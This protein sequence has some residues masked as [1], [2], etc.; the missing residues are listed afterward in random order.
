MA[1]PRVLTQQEVVDLFAGDADHWWAPRELEPLIK[2]SRVTLNRRLAEAVAAGLVESRGKG[3]LRQYRHIPR[4]D[5]TATASIHLPSQLVAAR[6]TAGPQWSKH[7]VA[8]RQYVQQPR[9]AR[10]PVTYQEHLVGSYVPNRTFW[11]PESLRAKLT[12]VGRSSGERPAGTYARDI[13][14]QLLIDLAWASSRLEGNRYSR[15]ET[16]NLIEAGTSADGKTRQESVMILNHRKAIEFLVDVAAHDD[17]LYR[18]VGNL[19]SLLMDGLLRDERGLGTIRQR[20]VVIEDSVYTP[21]QTPA[22]IERMYRLLC[23][24]AQ[25]IADPL[26][27]AF[28]LFTQLPYLQPFEDGNKRTS[29]VACNLPLARANFAPLAFLDVEDA[30][31][32]S[33]LLALYEKADVA[34]AVDLFEWAYLRSAQSYATVRQAMRDPDP[35]R[36]RLREPLNVALQGVV[37]RGLPLPQAVAELILAPEDVAPL[38]ALV[39]H[40]LASLNEFNHARYGLTYRQFDEY[41]NPR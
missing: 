25:A 38:T 1:A 40:E 23:G 28:F 34:V 37:A 11:L 26:E 31:Y 32:F 21:W 12:A 39:A 36:T 10:T 16:K 18:V 22:E 27:G 15:L 14:G 33:A 19:H 20:V 30:D 35:F 24:K 4:P 5:A 3:A 6:A 9:G 13:L 7:A 41:I 29:R 2:A 8:L 17:P